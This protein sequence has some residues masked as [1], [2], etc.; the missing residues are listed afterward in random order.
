MKKKL[1][2][3]LLTAAMVS[4]MFT[5]CGE[6]KGDEGSSKDGEITLTYWDGW[7]DAKTEPTAAAVQKALDKWEKEHP[8]IKIKVDH[9]TSGDGSYKT[10]IKSALAS[11]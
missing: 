8:D 9:T 3:V 6:S 11:D 1:L 4:A 5:A 7:V 2:S 10:K